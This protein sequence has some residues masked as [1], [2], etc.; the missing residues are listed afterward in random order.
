MRVEQYALAI[1]DIVLKISNIQISVGKV[2]FSIIL[3]S[4]SN[5]E[6]PLYEFSLKR[7][8]EIVILFI[9]S[10]FEAYSFQMI[11]TISKPDHNSSSLFDYLHDIG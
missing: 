6:A 1:E 9:D 7:D 5:I 3:Q 11:A 8:G 10:K 2:S 4:I